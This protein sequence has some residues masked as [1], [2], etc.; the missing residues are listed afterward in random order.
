MFFILIALDYFISVWIHQRLVMHK[1]YP[2]A[3]IGN[4]QAARSV[5]GITIVLLTLAIQQST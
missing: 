1:G 3:H 4:I 5:L 2:G